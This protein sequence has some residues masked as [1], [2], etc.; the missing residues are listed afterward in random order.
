MH[1]RYNLRSNKKNKNKQHKQYTETKH[2]NLIFLKVRPSWSFGYALDS[3]S[4]SK[5]MRIPINN[6]TKNY[7]FF[8][9]RDIPLSEVIKTI[10]DVV[11]KEPVNIINTDLELIFVKEK[12]TMPVTEKDESKNST[13]YPCIGFKN[14][15][16]EIEN[17]KLSDI[18]N[19]YEITNEKIVLYVHTSGSYSIPYG[20]IVS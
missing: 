14:I 11:P 19:A 17:K 12:Y 16:S 8:F 2:E 7:D 18:M 4:V 6:N 10:D 15:F 9:E 1:T 20:C 5:V 13:T 3:E